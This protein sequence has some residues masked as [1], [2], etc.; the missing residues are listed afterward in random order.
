MTYIQPKVTES[1]DTFA[2]CHNNN[3][4]ILLRPILEKVQ[5]VTP[6]WR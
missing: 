2:I 6:A 3:L 1:E 5:H 4:N